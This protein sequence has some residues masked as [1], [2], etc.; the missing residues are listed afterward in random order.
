MKRRNVVFITLASYFSN[1]FSLFP[2]TG[3]EGN[4][5]PNI[6]FI[7]ADD[8]GY[9]DIRKFN[10]GSAIPTPNLDRLCAEGML[11]TEAHS[12]SAVSTPTRYGL[13]T[14][15]YC[16]RGHLKRGVL[17]GF[18]PPLIER[19][20]LT[21]ASLLKTEGYHTAIIGKWHLGLGW[22]TTDGAAA[23][24]N[25]TE[26]GK[27]LTYTP[28]DAGFDKS[29]ILPASLDMVPYVYIEDRNVVDTVMT[30][31]EG[32][33]SPRGHFWRGGKAS[34]SFSI[35]D[36]LDHFTEKAEEYIMER[37][38]GDQPFFLYM[39]LTAPHTPWLP[40]NRFKGT[41]G[42]GDYGDFVVHVDD[43]VGKITSLIDNLGIRENTLI[44]FT[45]DNG[46]DW[47]PTDKATYPHRANYIWR[48]RKSD[49]WDGGHHVPLIIQYPAMVKAGTSSNA[50][51]CLTDMLATFAEMT[52]MA[53]PPGAA[54]D[55]QSF[56]PV[57]NGSSTIARSEVVHHSINGSFAI[58]QGNWKLINCSGSGG[59]SAAEDATLP[60]L[61]LYDME[62]DPEEKNNLYDKYP[63]KVEELKKLLRAIIQ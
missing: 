26:F 11:F 16:F 32:A 60:P 20:R 55:S 39:P 8:M 47:N 21:I 7:L 40:A 25:N 45:S 23:D 37:S 28:N 56:L 35:G 44:V 29:Y 52:G 61:Q 4:D 63:Q 51:V 43:V 53:V 31:I 36:C 33:D 62:T 46:A 50:L 5:R 42:A 49:V 15:R 3:N 22:Q 13:L 27:P 34:E 6:I 9:G 48:G 17:G 54:E 19:E 38:S 41:S 57:L 12:G 14:G 2:G 18:S 10:P 1:V 59:W 58:R 24:E 30:V